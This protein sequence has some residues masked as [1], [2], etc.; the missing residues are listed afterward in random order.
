MVSGNER[1]DYVFF[2]Y[3]VEKLVVYLWLRAVL[4]CMTKSKL[5]FYLA[6]VGLFDE[7]DQNYRLSKR[8][9]STE[10]FCGAVGTIVKKS[11][12]DGK[13]FSMLFLALFAS[14][15]PLLT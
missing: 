5:M 13:G 6:F 8:L 15:L 10:T 12:A 14:F 4:G 9:K 2:T 11:L 1:G 7:D 3:E